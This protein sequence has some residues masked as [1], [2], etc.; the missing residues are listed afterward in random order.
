MSTPSKIPLVT[1]VMSVFNGGRFL[2]EAL[3]SILSQTFHDFE[4]LVIDDGSTDSSAAT[5]DTLRSRDPRVRVFH[6][7]N[8]GLVHA[9]NRGCALAR[10]TYIARMDA[11]DISLPERLASQVAFLEAHPG[12]VLA[13]TAVAFIDS[14]GRVLQTVRYP[15]ANREIQTTL[16]DSSVF[17]HP[18]VLFSRTAFLS[19]GGYRDLPHAEDYD[20]WL[21]LAEIGELANLPQV[22]LRYRL[23]PQQVSVLHCHAQALGS[24]AARGL[25]IARRNGEHDRLDNALPITAATLSTLGISDR[26]LQTTVGRSYLS[27]IRLMSLIRDHTSALRLLAILHSA[28]LERAE[29]WVIADSYLCAGRVSWAQARYLHSLRSCSVAIIKRPV[30][31]GRPIK[32]ALRATIAAIRNRFGS[33]RALPASTRKSTPRLVTSH[34]SETK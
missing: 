29:S 28:G 10:G 23:H 17:W 25:A 11:D 15:T 6:Q 4:L 22:L 12:I 1:V 2:P 13:G 18:T 31:L 9:L 26:D 21:R 30:L 24:L 3:E 5:L 8:R 27:S 7:E 34:L 19:V 32:S 16:L 14:F 33:Y 20:L